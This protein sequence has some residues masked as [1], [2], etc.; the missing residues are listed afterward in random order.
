[1]IPG[2]SPIRLSIKRSFDFSGDHRAKARR[3]L[4]VGIALSFLG[5]MLP[6]FKF[7]FDAE[8]WYGGFDL[9]R[10]EGI[11][12]LWLIVA[13]YVVLAATILVG[14]LPGGLVL[15]L[16][17]VT[18]L[19]T[20]VMVSFATGDALQEVRSLDSPV[21]SVGLFLMLPGHGALLWGAI[22]RAIIP[23]IDEAVSYIGIEVNDKKPL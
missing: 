10:N 7:D 16:A 6:W 1:M 20:M 8:W 14:D 19:A 9:L 18:I 23:V 3:W 21:L 4:L 22:Y 11:N 15:T 17:V 12:E 13:L 5:F 2:N